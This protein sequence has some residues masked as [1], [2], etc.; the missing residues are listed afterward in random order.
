MAIRRIGFVGI[1]NMGRPMAANLAR[2]GFELSVYD[3]RVE[4]SLEFASAHGAHAAHSLQALAQH[5]QCIVAMLPDHATVARVRTPR[6][7]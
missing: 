4:R 7:P 6:H 3:A 2:A 5:A 1:G